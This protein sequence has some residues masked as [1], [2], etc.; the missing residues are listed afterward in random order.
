MPVTDVIEALKI[1]ER[2]IYETSIYRDYYEGRHRY[3]FASRSFRNNYMWVLRNSRE[4]MCPAIVHSHSDLVEIKSWSGSGAER[5]DEVSS[6]PAIGLNTALNL[7][8]RESFRTGDAYILVWPDRE[9]NPRPWYHRSDRV[10]FK[11]DPEYP[12]GVEWYAKVWPGND[13]FGRVNLYYV[14]RVER[15]ITTVKVRFNRDDPVNWPTYPQAYILDPDIPQLNYE[16]DRA[17][18]VHLAF[19]A[20]EQGGYGRSILTDAIPIQDALNKSVADLIVSSDKFALPLRALMN[21]DPQRR[22]DPNTGTVQEEKLVLNES[23]KDIIGVK[24]PGPLTQLEIPDAQKLIAIQDAYINK[25]SRVV[26]IP[27]TDINPEIGNVPSGTALRILSSRRTRA[28]RD[29]EADNTKAISD[30]LELLGV[31]DAIPAWQD[32]APMDDSERIANAAVKVGQLGYPLSEV[33]DDL[34]ESP[35]DIDRILAAA[36]EAQQRA[37]AAAVEAFRQGTGSDLFG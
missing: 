35:D 37:G 4:N 3:P 18:W 31:D 27:P 30:A 8:F 9:G 11:E 28:I 12:D 36:E 2:R 26:G 1:R 17:P 13:N 32:P 14:D 6:D 5:A 20:D 23:D 10:V 34:G 21:Y 29:Y 22:I 7:A 24:G 16:Y 25:M 19:D 15:Y 33:L